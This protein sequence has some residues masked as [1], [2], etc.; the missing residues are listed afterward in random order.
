MWMTNKDRIVDLLR[1]SIT[2]LDDD[3]IAL[4]LR[5]EPRQTV[6]RMCRELERTGVIDRWKDPGFK[7]VNRLRQR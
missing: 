7:I 5:I 6:N 1:R 2:P 3:E 4:R